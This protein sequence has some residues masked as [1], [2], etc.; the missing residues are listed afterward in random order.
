MALDMDWLGRI[1]GLHTNVTLFPGAAVP[2]SHQSVQ[3]FAT[4]SCASQ[5]R[6]DS[7]RVNDLRNGKAI[8]VQLLALNETRRKR[9]DTR[10]ATSIVLFRRNDMQLVKRNGQQWRFITYVCSKKP[11]VLLGAFV[12][13]VRSTH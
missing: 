8:E 13:I 5:L 7:G 4:N 9:G 1:V 2:T 12:C 6:S 11:V 10:I 3:P